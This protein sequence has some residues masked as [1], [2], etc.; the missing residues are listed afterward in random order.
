M[1]GISAQSLAGSRLPEAKAIPEKAGRCAAT[2]VL[3]VHPRLD[4]GGAADDADFDNGT[5]IDY[6]NDGYQVSYNRE[7]ALIRSKPGDP[8]TMC[9][10]EIDRDC[11]PDEG[12]RLFLVTNGRTHES[13]IL[14]DAQHKCGG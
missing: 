11:G 3:E 12:G 1:Q 13:W 9:L 6:A 14:P 2:S 4:N 7:E 8:V 5:G 10:V